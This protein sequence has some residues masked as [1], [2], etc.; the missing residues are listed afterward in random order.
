MTALAVPGPRQR[1]QV[2]VGGS[3]RAL[4]R[5]AEYRAGRR[6]EEEEVHAAD[7]ECLVQRLCATDFRPHHL[8]Q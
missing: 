1:V 4:S 2:G 5:D 7:R 3:V 8:P 6:H